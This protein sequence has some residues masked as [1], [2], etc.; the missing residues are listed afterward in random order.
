MSKAALAE[1]LT[2]VVNDQVDLPFLSEDFEA[3]L[4]R[5]VVDQAVEHIPERFFP[6]LIDLNDGLTD[7]ERAEHEPR[8]LEEVTEAITGQI[9]LPFRL[10]ASTAVRSFV[11]PV[12]AKVFDYLQP[13]LAVELG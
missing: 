6:L 4:I 9:P 11:Q 8:I 7:E 12:V 10:F 2:D 3:S 5:P 1:A 13:N